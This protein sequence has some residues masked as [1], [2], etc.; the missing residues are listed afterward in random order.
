MGVDSV[1]F[2]GKNIPGEGKIWKNFKIEKA[3]WI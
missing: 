2:W 3:K 1:N